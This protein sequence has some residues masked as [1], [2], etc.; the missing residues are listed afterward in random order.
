MAR[1]IKKT[2]DSHGIFRY[3][4]KVELVQFP[5]SDWEHNPV[6][7]IVKDIPQRYWKYDGTNTVAEMSQP[8]KDA[9]DASLIEGEATPNQ[10]GEFE[11]GNW[12]RTQNRYLRANGWG[13]PCNLMPSVFLSEGR[14]SGLLF[15]NYTD[16]ADSDIQIRIN[17]TLVYTWQVRDKRLAYKTNEL[18]SITFACGECD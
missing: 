15:N 10:F 4:R 17:G 14:L 11:F 3:L 2:P 6:I 1:V 8:E 9:V 12:G 7:S 16:N 13:M 18:S 5:S